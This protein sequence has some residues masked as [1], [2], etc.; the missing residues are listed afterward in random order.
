LLQPLRLLA[1]KVLLIGMDIRNPKLGA[2]FIP[3]R[4]LTNYLASK[5]L[6]IQDLIVKYEGYEDL[7][8][9]S[10][11]PPNPAELLMSG[12]VD[13]LFNDLKAHYDYIVVD[14]PCL[15]TDTLLAADCFIYVAR[16][17]I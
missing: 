7:H 9:S 10:S 12:K 8:A 3:E 16:A 2:Y 17:I 11:I 13:T 6:K 5:D 15:V 14:T 1:K 4:G